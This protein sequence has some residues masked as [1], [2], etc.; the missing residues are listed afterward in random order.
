MEPTIATVVKPHAGGS[1]IIAADN[2]ALT[3]PIAFAQPPTATGGTNLE[4]RGGVGTT[5]GPPHRGRAGQHA[6][7]EGG[8]LAFNKPI[9]LLP[10][11]VREG[12][13]VLEEVARSTEGTPS[14]RAAH[15]AARQERGT[16][17]LVRGAAIAQ[18]GQRVETSTFR[19]DDK[20]L[21]RPAIIFALLIAGSNIV[22]I[23][24]LSGPFIGLFLFIR[25]DQLGTNAK[26][27]CEEIQE[28]TN[29]L[30]LGFHIRD[31]DVSEQ[32]GTC[33]HP[34]FNA[35]DQGRV[36]DRQPGKGT[37]DQSAKALGKRLQ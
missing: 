2:F 3:G 4:I 34:S 10:L 11:L 14:G 20:A 17:I 21:E 7:I 30:L 16:R 27:R 31:D 6:R 36:R 24:L 26:N 23:L 19:I 33:R 25:T 9:R 18:N 1:R 35:G 15:F 5:S 22:L 12:I 32:K 13:E 29:L 28:L 8:N 37:G